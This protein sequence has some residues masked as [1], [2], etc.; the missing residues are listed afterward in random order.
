[1]YMGLIKMD[2]MMGLVLAMKME[3]LDGKGW[4]V[5]VKGVLVTYSIYQKG[6]YVNLWLS[7]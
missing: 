1:M 5:C 4:F 2:M 6:W 3:D 7:L